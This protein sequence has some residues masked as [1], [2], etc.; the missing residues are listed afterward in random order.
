MSDETIPVEETRS[1][2]VTAGVRWLLASMVGVQ[3]LEWTLIRSE[4]LR[5]LFAFQRA[6]LDQARWWS[7]ATY[8]LVHPSFT[9]LALTVY[10]LLVFGPRLERAWGTRRFVGFVALAALGGWIVHLFVAGSAPL[11]G[12]SAIAFGIMGAYAHR[13]GG[14][15][16]LL[17][18]GFSARERWTVAFVIAVT[19]LTGLQESVGGGM[20]F[21]AHL[22]GLGAVWIF[23]RAENVRLVER[24]REGVSAL[25][26]DPPEDQPPRAVP[27]TL[28]RAR[29]QRET[30]DEVVAR[31]NAETA[32]ERAPA[33]RRPEP[34]QA[35]PA[36][37]ADPSID[38]ILDKISAEGMDHL[39]PDE[40]RVLD[41][42]SRRL[43]DR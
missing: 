33:R 8:P 42:H 13:W 32:R 26:D 36:A 6:D 37:D 16:R 28:P 10:A 4:E 20:P 22:G 27:R 17:P 1:P 2:H 41:D 12:G 25:P 5:A 9:L 30:I 21:L 11:M 34:E 23:S 7:T 38:A 15:E 19:L 24:I 14:E 35:G 18:G 29:A 43:R 3:V 40:R 31:T 39:T